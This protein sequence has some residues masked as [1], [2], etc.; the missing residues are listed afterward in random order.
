MAM[1]APA[2]DRRGG[3]WRCLFGEV[4]F[5]LFALSFLFKIAMGLNDSFPEF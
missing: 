3:G 1:M 4:V 5:A 2:K